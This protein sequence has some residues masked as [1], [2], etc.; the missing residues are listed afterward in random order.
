[1]GGVLP[2]DHC[3]LLMYQTVERVYVSTFRY[4]QHLHYLVWRAPV[5]H[6]NKHPR[7]RQLGAFWG[8]LNH[9][10]YSVYLYYGERLHLL[11]GYPSPGPVSAPIPPG[12]HTNII[13]TNYH[14][15][16][17]TTFRHHSESRSAS[18]IIL[19]PPSP[20]SGHRSRCTTF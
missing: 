17:L 1:M 3:A 13:G 15:R 20:T 10:S 2:L 16:N 6:N 7:S 5:S 9:Y 12:L 11:V 8:Y 4:F 19:P 18:S 14:L